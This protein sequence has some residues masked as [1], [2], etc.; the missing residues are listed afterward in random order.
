[1][2]L[3]GTCHFVGFVVR[4][5][6]FTSDVYT[7]DRYHRLSFQTV[8]KQVFSRLVHIIKHAEFFISCK[9]KKKKTFGVLSTYILPY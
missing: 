7:N 9:L 5:L 3:L 6:K 1:M 4:Q 8:Y 2:S